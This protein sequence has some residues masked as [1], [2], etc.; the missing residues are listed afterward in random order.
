M[1]A[2]VLLTMLPFTWFGMVL[3]ISFLETPLK[4]RAPGMTHALGVGIGRLVFKALN[5]VEAVLAGA[6]I[7]AWLLA[8]AAIS[9]AAGTLLVLAI[10]ALA[11]QM[12]ILRPAMAR[13]TRALSLTAL[14]H[15][16]GTPVKAKVGTSTHIVYITSE[17][18]KVLALPVA[19]ILIVLG[20][21]G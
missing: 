21:A 7:I 3:A 8:P 15:D 13:R 18:L 5:S 14:T 10:A 19:G 2:V 16:G 4:F 17:G 11:L 1:P 6:L 9:A 12:L 20:V